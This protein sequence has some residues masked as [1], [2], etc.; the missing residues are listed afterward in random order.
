MNKKFNLLALAAAASACGALVLT[1]CGGSGKTHIVLFK[2]DGLRDT[3]SEK[4]TPVS[5]KAQTIKHGKKMKLPIN[6]EEAEAK[7][8]AR[9]TWRETGN[10]TLDHIEYYLRGWSESTEDETAGKFDQRRFDYATPITYDTV[11]YPLY[12][13]KKVHCLTLNLRYD[14]NNESTWN[15]AVCVANHVWDEN[16]FE[17]GTSLKDFEAK[18]Y[19]C[20]KTLPNG[21]K[22]TKWLTWDSDNNKYVPFNWSTATITEDITLVA[23][24]G[25]E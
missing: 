23:S 12:S 20:V 5:F 14:D 15:D 19:S 10:G 18:T 24:Y 4:L 13:E 11:L 22:V 8:Y 17:T 3:L 6:F 21:Y 7:E 16:W 9:C 1:S 2:T 25:A